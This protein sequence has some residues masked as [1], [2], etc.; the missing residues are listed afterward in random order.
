MGNRDI[1]S[2]LKCKKSGDLKLEI[3]RFYKIVSRSITLN[4]S[5]FKNAYNLVLKYDDN[6]F[7]AGTNENFFMLG[8]TGE[9]LMYRKITKDNK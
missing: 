7:I 1:S 4:N 9:N 8:L 5:R 3:T 6:A 2:F